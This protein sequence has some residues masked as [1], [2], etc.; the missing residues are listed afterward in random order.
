[1]GE[2][3]ARRAQFALAA[4]YYR[5]A[6]ETVA[7]TQTPEFIKAVNDEYSKVRR[8]VTELALTTTPKVASLRVFDDTNDVELEL[9]LFLEVGQHRLR[10][11]APGYGAV[12]KTFTAEP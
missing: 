11:E 9:P 4:R 2:I 10:A 8:E 5:H 6:I 7:P 12:T 1:M 3:C